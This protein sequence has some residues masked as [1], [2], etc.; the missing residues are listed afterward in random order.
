MDD[1]AEGACSWTKSLVVGPLADDLFLDQIS[2]CSWTQPWV[3]RPLV[4][5]ICA[6]SSFCKNEEFLMINM[7]DIGGKLVSYNLSTQRFRD[8]AYDVDG[9]GL[10][11]WACFYVKSLVSV[12]RR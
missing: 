5:G 6:L 1:G 10:H 2:G 7:K 8:A 11:D 3:I 9:H 12:R 4:N